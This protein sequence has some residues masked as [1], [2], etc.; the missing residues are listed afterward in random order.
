MTQVAGGCLAVWEGSAAV[1]P[2][3]MGKKNLILNIFWFVAR[4]ATFN[5]GLVCIPS[6]KFANL[7]S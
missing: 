2:V 4:N 5:K 7:L 3:D 6:Y 1:F